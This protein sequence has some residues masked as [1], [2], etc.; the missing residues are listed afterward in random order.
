MFT[1]AIAFLA[2]TL[3]VCQLPALEPLERLAPLLCA[4]F[5]LLMWRRAILAA[6]LVAGILWAWHFGEATRARGLDPQ[7]NSRQWT[8]TG[9][10]ISVP[11]IAD[12]HTSFDLTLL[13]ASTTIANLRVLRLAWY[14]TRVNVR[15]GER[16]RLRVRLRHPH[17]LRNPGDYDY[18]GKLFD[19]GVNATG[20]VVRCPCN[21]RVAA[22]G[23]RTPVLRA[24]EA[25]AHGIAAALPTSPYVGI[26]QDLAVGLD[27]GVAREQ[28]QV[29]SATGTTHLMAISGFHVAGVA[30]LAMWLVR[31]V[32]RCF[33]VRTVARADVESVAGLAAAIAYAFLAG[34]S[35]PTQ[36][37]LVTLAVV[38]GARILRRSAAIWDLLGLALIAVLL[39]DPLASLGAGFWLSFAT[40]AGILFAL[41]GRIMQRSGWRD[42][43]PAQAA[44]TL[45][46]LPLT[47]ALFGT[48]SVLGPLINLLAIPIFSLLLV[49][50]ILTGVVLLA[51]PAGVGDWWF[52]LIDQFIAFSW[53]HFA[54]LAASPLALVHVPQLPVWALALLSAGLLWLLTPWPPM[55]RVLGLAFAV[56]AI[57]WRPEPLAPGA[58]ELTVLDVGQ[59]LAAYVATR[60]HAL[61]FDTGPASRSGRA[62]AEVSIVPF[63]EQRARR[64]LDV[65][66]LSHSDRDHVGGVSAV[67]ATVDVGREY[68]GGDLRF[69]VRP[70]LRDHRSRSCAAGEAW[71]W[72]DVR[73]RFLHPTLVPLSDNDGSCVLEVSGP[74]GSVLLTGDIEAAAERALLARGELRRVDVVVV[75][76]HGSRSSSGVDFVAALAPRWALVAVGYDNRW[77]FP[78]P[79]VVERWEAAGATTLSTARSGAISLRFDPA[80][81]APRPEQYRADARRFWH[82]D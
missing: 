29:F 54:T 69:A 75:P 77:H 49:P 19:A 32:W 6:A 28:W 64:H 57:V 37:T 60:E 26:L 10:V 50:A 80:G 2:G 81:L 62:A 24:R 68:V 43:L 55:V 59:G 3:I 33:V 67:Q 53:P 1:K 21:E 48:V 42:L 82:V 39:L 47:M 34:L 66:V 65:L 20:Y 18:E 35:V 12:D 9:Q 79:E 25:I 16:W 27:D 23:W 8:V 71:M 40:V 31:L 17:G 45:C 46:L 22:A 76:H 14:D 11:E 41:E 78:Q 36:R 63:L 74:G 51:L 58:F 70:G 13:A 5:V 52:R 38:L 7:L 56:P 4:G 72:D 73:F 61:L 44:A 15:A 30:L